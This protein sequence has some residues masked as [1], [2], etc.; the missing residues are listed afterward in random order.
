MLPAQPSP[1]P[2]LLSLSRLKLWPLASAMLT[3]IQAFTM[4]FPNP[5]LEIPK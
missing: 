1:Q 5:A 4:V 2:I 3:S